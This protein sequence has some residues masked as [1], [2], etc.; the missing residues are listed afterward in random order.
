MAYLL[1]LK[2]FADPRGSLTVA[3]RE[4]PFAI[5]RVYYIYGV[6]ADSVRAG[7]RHYKNIQALICLGGRCEVFVNNGRTKQT[8]LLDSPEKGLILNPE[9][10]HTMQHFSKDALLL[11]MASEHYDIRDYIDEPYHD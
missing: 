2:T 6:S 1:T 10:W 9:D 8:F 3:D 5:Q 4:I 11:V 7:H